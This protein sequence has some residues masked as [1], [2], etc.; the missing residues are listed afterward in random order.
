MDETPLNILLVEDHDLVRAGLGLIF[1]AVE[2]VGKVWEASSGEECIALIRERAF[3]VVF[4]DIGLP[5]MDGLSASLRLL[6]IDEDMRIIILTG[7]KQR[8]LSRVVLQAG[9]RGYMTKSSATSEVG[10]AIESVMQGGTYLSREIANQMALEA[11]NRGDSVNPI[12]NLSRRELQVALLLMN[13]HKT[14]EVGE[15]LF[16]SSKTVSTYKR[17]AYEKLRVDSLAELVEL[18]INSGFLGQVH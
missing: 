11:I 15:M 8:P 2:S 4:M 6:Q 3:D 7:L 13:G 16:L 1:E 14:T 12:D 5:G 17:R 10:L 9:I 18:G